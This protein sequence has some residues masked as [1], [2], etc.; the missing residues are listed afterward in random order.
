MH[1]PFFFSVDGRERDFSQAERWSDE[2][3]FANRA[4][5]MPEKQP[6][7]LGVDHIR[8]SDQGVYR[9]RVDFKIA[10]TKNSRVNLTVIVP[11][12][13]MMITDE[14]GAALTSVVG[15]FPEGASFTL[16][17]DVFGAKPLPMVIWFRNDLVVSNMSVPLP[18]AGTTHVR[19]EIRI[20]GLGRRDVHSELTCQASNNPRTQPLAATL[21]VDMNFGPIDVMILGSN[22][23]LSAGRKYDL[24]CQSSGSRPPATITWWRN[25]HRLE[26][27]KDTTSN[28]G[29]TT[30]STL[31]F[32]PK[33]EDD[34]K[35]LS[36][37][38]ENKMVSA[39]SLEDGWKLEIH[40]TP[41][42][43]IVLGTSLNPDNIREGTD[44]YFDC[45]VHAHP[46]VYKVEWRHNVSIFI[47][48]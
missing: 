35:Y 15:P 10:Q 48:I 12:Q 26:K 19:S 21:H 33:K 29:N 37:R 34:G 32:I 6:A 7:E 11:P 38:S 2:N 42:A 28:D 24:L 27:T 36:C 20:T 47:F 25:G 30:T 41:E 22:Q 4:Y 45:I 14:T 8:D 40:Y 39:E 16:R 44:V 1:N 23:P 31:S 46:P 3:V 13:R 18:T 5:F 17:C 9:C 43:K